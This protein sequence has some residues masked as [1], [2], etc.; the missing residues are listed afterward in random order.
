M[1]LGAF[2]AAKAAGRENEMK[3]SVPTAS[4]CRPEASE[5][6]NMGAGR[7]VH[8]STCAK[9]AAD[10]AGRSTGRVEDDPAALMA[11]CFSCTG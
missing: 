2:L 4:P 7:R 10:S 6:F 9:E 3:S 11:S 5:P 8:L 1:A